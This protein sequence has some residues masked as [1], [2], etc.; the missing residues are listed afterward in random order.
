[1]TG[2]TNNAIR[3]MFEAAERAAA[4]LGVKDV[5]VHYHGGSEALTR[6]AN[7]AIHQ[8][9]AESSQSLSVRLVAGQKTA[10]AATNRVDHEGIERCVAEAFALTKAMADDDQLLPLADPSPIDERPERYDEATANCSPETRARGVAEA[11]RAAE[12]GLTAAGIYSTEHSIEAVLNTRGVSAF[13][14]ETMARFSITT[15]RL[16]G[17]FGGPRFRSAGRT[18]SMPWGNG[19]PKPPKLMA[20]P[21]GA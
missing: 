15:M 12:W 21:R 1:M 19:P 4:R 14:R 13:H 5:E 2:E 6:F 8:N 16:L 17:A 10:R 3:Q 7:N 18:K 20:A 9:V 11:I